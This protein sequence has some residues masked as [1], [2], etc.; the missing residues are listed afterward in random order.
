MKYGGRKN[1]MLGPNGNHVTKMT[2]EEYENWQSWN[3]WPERINDPP[4]T[5]E[6]P[7][8]YKGKQ[9][10]VTS[11]NNKYVI[12]SQPDFREIISNKNFKELLEMP[13][14]DGMSFHTLIA[15]L[16]FED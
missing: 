6:T 1:Q 5:V 11:L 14:I 4:L 13:F 3:E 15:E 10:M 9:Y 7:F 2:M 8:W 16:L 12:V